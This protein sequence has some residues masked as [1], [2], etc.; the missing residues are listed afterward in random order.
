MCDHLS[1]HFVNFEFNN[2][3]SISMKSCKSILFAVVCI[4]LSSCSI[5]YNPYITT[6]DEF[7][8]IKK[9]TFEITLMPNEFMQSTVQNAKIIFERFI[10]ANEETV[11]VYFVISRSGSSFNMEKKCYVMANEKVYEIEIGSEG[12]EYKTNHENS[13]ITTIT[14][15]SANV[16]TESISKSNNYN[17]YEEKLVLRLT[18]EIINSLFKTDELSFRFYFG[19]KEGTFSFKRY[20]LKRV[21]GLFE[22]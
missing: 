19:P 21:K 2:N 1:K 6:K 15:D 13:S 7:K 12:T 5:L 9:S 11:N 14:K 18:P 22:I 4:S 8:N 20:S 17:W 16:K 10:K 3:L